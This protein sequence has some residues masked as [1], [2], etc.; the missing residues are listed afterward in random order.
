MILPDINLLVFALDRHSPHHLPAKRWWNACLTGT[1]QIGIPWPVIL[2]VVRILG[3]PRVY[4]KPTRPE[5][6][7]DQVGKWLSLPHIHLLDPSTAHLA[8]LR[9]LLRITGVTGNLSSDAH[10][11]AIAIERG[12]TVHSNDNDFARFPGLSWT[13]PLAP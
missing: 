10:L 8:I 1:A 9:N 2:G 11:A 12:F 4:A 6:V 7:L 5:E 3:H 13:N